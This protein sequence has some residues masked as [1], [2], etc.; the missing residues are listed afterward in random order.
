[1]A[2]VL[3]FYR[4]GVVVRHRGVVTD[5]EMLEMERGIYSYAYPA[6]LEFQVID[7]SRV[8]DFRASPEMMRDI[9]RMDDYMKALS[10]LENG[11]ESDTGSVFE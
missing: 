4:N 7:L 10:D 5:E 1:M 8:S 9:G 3:E 2:T 6:P 11:E